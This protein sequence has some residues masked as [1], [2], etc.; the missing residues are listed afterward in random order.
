MRSRF[1][2]HAI[3]ITGLVV[4]IGALVQCARIFR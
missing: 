4:I 1:I 2:I 3:E